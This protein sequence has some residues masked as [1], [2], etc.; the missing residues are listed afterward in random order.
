MHPAQ[1]NWVKRSHPKAYNGDRN[2][3]GGLQRN[4]DSSKRRKETVEVAKVTLNAGHDIL[5][6]HG[7][8]FGNFNPKR[9]NC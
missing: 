1:I 5:I 6:Y 9:L 8:R 7:C 2:A 4:D 3:A